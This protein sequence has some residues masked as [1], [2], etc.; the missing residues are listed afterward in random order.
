MYMFTGRYITAGSTGRVFFYA[1]SFKGGQGFNLNVQQTFSDMRRI[2]D[3]TGA[4]LLLAKDMTHQ[5]RQ[6][7]LWAQDPA[8]RV[9]QPLDPT[10]SVG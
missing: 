10:D 2:V 3:S 4:Q 7:Q 6:Y 9:G 8:D 5:S 1:S